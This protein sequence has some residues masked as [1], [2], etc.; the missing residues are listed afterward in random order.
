MFILFNYKKNHN[1][2]LKDLEPAKTNLRERLSKDGERTGKIFETVLFEVGNPDDIV[3]YILLEEK[4]RK[5][6]L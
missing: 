1:I 2:N 4:G 6:I 3:N 5:M